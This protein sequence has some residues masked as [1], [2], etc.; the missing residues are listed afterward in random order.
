MAR[1][2]PLPSCAEA[3]WSTV[4]MS[5]LIGYRLGMDLLPG[6]YFCT[7]PLTGRERLALPSSVLGMLLD[8][9]SI[10]TG[11]P[12]LT[13]AT[14]FRASTL[15]RVL[16]YDI[17]NS[18]TNATSSFIDMMLQLRHRTLVQLFLPVI[19]CITLLM[20]MVDTFTGKA[21]AQAYLTLLGMSYIGAMVIS[22]GEAMSGFGETG[23]YGGLRPVWGKAV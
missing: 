16:V 4:S 11:L 21:L 23:Q 15:P 2:I 10:A 3:P 17:V 18:T 6:I 12:C 7:I 13:M 5:R 8:L 22:T 19:L 1:C 14:R 20:V 9:T